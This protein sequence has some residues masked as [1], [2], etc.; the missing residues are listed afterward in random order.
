[1]GNKFR[2]IPIL[3]LKMGEVNALKHLQAEYKAIVTPL[4][5]IPPIPYDYAQ[6]QAS[7]TLDKHIEKVSQVVKSC[8]NE[9]MFLDFSYVA[10]DITSQFVP[11]IEA[12]FNDIANN[13]IKPIPVVYLSMEQEYTNMTCSIAKK[14]NNGVCIRI[15]NADFEEENFPEQIDLLLKNANII[16]QYTDIILDMGLIPSKGTGPISVGIKNIVRFFPQFTEW[17]SIT[18]AATSFPETL[19][20]FS[21]QTATVI[22]RPEWGIWEQL[23]TAGH[24]SRPLYYGDYGIASPEPFQM[25]PRMM[26][27][28]AKIKYTLDEQWLIV[29]GTGI[30]RGGSAQFHSL[31]KWLAES[32]HYYKADFSW[33]DNFID[34]CAKKTT[35]PGSQTS[36]VSVG[37]NHHFAVTAAKLSKLS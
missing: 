24:T 4:F 7:K 26:K 12:Q 15:E 30:K 28:G 32:K 21:S 19:A 34:E 2:Y 8:C 9:S 33:G 3:K 35:G 31:A 13:G 37:M 25:D 6:E 1:M 16:P 29:K 14:L 17:R 20:S 27:L 22:D 5:E 10:D 11:N 18:L 36:W 23:A